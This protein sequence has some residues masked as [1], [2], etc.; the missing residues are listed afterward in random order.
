M[1]R[2]GWLGVAAASGLVAVCVGWGDK[3]SILFGMPILNLALC[4]IFTLV[5]CYAV[6]RAGPD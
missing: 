4:F 5:A 6:Y 2:N 3:G 1:T